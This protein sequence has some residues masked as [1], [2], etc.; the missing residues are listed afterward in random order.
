MV[1]SAKKSVYRTVGEAADETLIVDI[2]LETSRTESRR[3][4]HILESKLS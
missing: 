1:T 4:R 2:D 3:N